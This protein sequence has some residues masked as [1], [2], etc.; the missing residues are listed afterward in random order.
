MLGWTKLNMGK[1]AEAKILFN[2]ALTIRPGDQSATSGL[3]L[4]K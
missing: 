1:H 4:I 3:K 2:H